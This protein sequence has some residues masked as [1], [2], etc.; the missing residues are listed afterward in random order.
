LKENDYFF[1]L[2]DKFNL[3]LKVMISSKNT[4]EIVLKKFQQGFLIKKAAFSFLNSAA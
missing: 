1:F 4:R 3:G 2:A